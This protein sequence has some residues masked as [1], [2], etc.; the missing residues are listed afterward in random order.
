MP[1]ESTRQSVFCASLIQQFRL[2]PPFAYRPVGA[3]LGA[4]GRTR[5]K[6]AFSAL[7]ITALI[8]IY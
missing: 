7:P 8:T 5:V 4:F 3:P 2:G 1:D 6:S